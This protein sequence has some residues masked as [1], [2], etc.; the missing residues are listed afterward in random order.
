[1]GAALSG[2]FGGN[3]ESER[4]RQRVE[5]LEARLKAEEEQRSREAQANQLRAEADKRTREAQQQ[6]NEMRDQLREMQQSEAK[7]R[8]ILKELGYSPDEPKITKNLIAK[9]RKALGYVKG[10]QNVV[11]VGNVNVGKSSLVNALRGVLNRDATAA[12]V[13]AS[14]VTLTSGRYETRHHPDLVLFDTPGA[15]TLDVPAFR[16]FYEHQLFAFDTVVLVHDTTLTMPDIRLLQLCSIA[17]LPY[18]AVRTR[19]D[20]HIR[21]YAADGWTLEEARERFI[22]EARQDAAQCQRQVREKWPE[23]GITIRDHIVSA[24]GV[25]SILEGAASS[26]DPATAYIDEW[27]LV[28]ALSLRGAAPAITAN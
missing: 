1:M 3:E 28:C 11:F 6:L 15:G 10:K 24:T 20:N 25:R 12:P 14:Q 22:A 27:D 2:L 4:L 16:Y 8:E 13:G 23:H 7:Q 5:E 26:N 17:Q 9:A 18:I 19:A 21:N